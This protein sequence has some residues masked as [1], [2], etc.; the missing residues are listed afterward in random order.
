MTLL[1]LK[2]KHGTAADE[3]SRYNGTVL[4]KPNE[5]RTLKV[6]GGEFTSMKEWAEKLR[7]GKQMSPAI[8]SR[9]PSSA[10]SSLGDESMESMEF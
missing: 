10:L 8:S 9:R 6:E 7:S 3:E 2:K 1:V 5:S 4:G